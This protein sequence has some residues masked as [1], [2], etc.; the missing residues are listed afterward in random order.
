MGFEIFYPCYGCSFISPC[1]AFYPPSTPFTRFFKR[2]VFHIHLKYFSSSPKNQVFISPVR[3]PPK[4]KQKGEPNLDDLEIEMVSHKVFK[5]RMKKHHR[6]LERENREREKGKGVFKGKRG[7]S[8]NYVTKVGAVSC[9][10]ML[11][12][13]GS[14]ISSEP[15]PAL[16]VS[17]IRAVS[18]AFATFA[19]VGAV[20]VAATA[21]QY[22]DVS[23]TPLTLTQDFKVTELQNP[24]LPPKTEIMNEVCKTMPECEGRLKSSIDEGWRLFEDMPHKTKVPRCEDDA[25]RI[26]FKAGYENFI[27]RPKTYK[28]PVNYLPIMKKVLIELL[29]YGFIVP[30][31][32]PYCSPCMI[33]P[34]PHQEGVAFEDLKWRLVVDLRDINAVTVTMHHRIPNIQNM[35]HKLGETKVLSCLDL[36]K[37][38]HQEDL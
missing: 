13:A 21:E 18:T 31:K 29:K 36:A 16:M 22:S 7:A 32:S 38:S 33:I 35:W 14:I 8:L 30:S 11:A 15:D 1:R 17:C 27:P 34:K 26:Q 12:A 25:M 19:S 20:A 5:K 28:T 6:D 24:Y 4:V 23:A 37:G 2:F 10:L 9:M 3:V